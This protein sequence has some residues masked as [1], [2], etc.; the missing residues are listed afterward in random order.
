MTLTYKQITISISF[1]ISFSIIFYKD[2]K[3]NLSQNS[4]Q[5]KKI[6]KYIQKMESG[7]K[8]RKRQTNV[9]RLY[10]AVLVR[11]EVSA[12]AEERKNET[13]TYGVI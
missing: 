11:N 13:F 8:K 10:C 4:Q 7:E 9:Y 6:R 5:I 12:E 2:T 1:I 3:K